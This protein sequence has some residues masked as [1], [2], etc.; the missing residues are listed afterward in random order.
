MSFLGWVALTGAL[1]LVMALS[2]A[3]VQRLPISTA[4]VYLAVGMLLGPL[5]LGALSF[6]LA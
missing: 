4:I 6:D 3:W 2:S 1:L 5:G